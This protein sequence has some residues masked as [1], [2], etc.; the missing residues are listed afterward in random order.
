M[1]TWDVAVRLQEDNRR[2]FFNYANMKTLV[3]KDEVA[4]EM[5]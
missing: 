3:G 2:S 5:Y 4:I 1:Q